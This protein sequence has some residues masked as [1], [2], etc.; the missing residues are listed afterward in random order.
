MDTSRRRFFGGGK[1]VTLVCRPPWSVAEQAFEASCTRCG[2]CV[3]SCSTGLL[4]VGSGGFPVA[5]FDVASCTFCGDCAVACKAGAILGGLDR[6]PW[7][8]GISIGSACL[9][10]QGV[11]C[12]VCGELCE[13]GA[14]RFRPRLGGVPLPELDEDVCTGCGACLAPCPVGALQRVVLSSTK[15]IS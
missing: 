4:K 3:R 8:F 7:N 13:F 14:I 9:A 6:T 11:E 5:D 1:S 12:R 2:D 10:G 15:E